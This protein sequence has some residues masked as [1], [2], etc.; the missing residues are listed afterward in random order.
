[1]VVFRKC[2]VADCEAG[3]EKCDMEKPIH[4]DN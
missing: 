4:L 3:A 2:R 1:L